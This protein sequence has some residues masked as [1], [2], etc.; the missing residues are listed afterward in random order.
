MKFILI[1]WIFNHYIYDHHFHY[2]ITSFSIYQK[3][4]KSI[5]LNCLKNLFVQLMSKYLN[6]KNKFRTRVNNAF[7]FC[8][9]HFYL[10]DGAI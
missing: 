10:Y 6:K 4:F 3:L 8:E 2:N 1:Y 5:K 9:N 7:I